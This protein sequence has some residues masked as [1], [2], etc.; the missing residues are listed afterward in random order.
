[1]PCAR[2]CGHR[3]CRSCTIA[4]AGALLAA[5]VSRLVRLQG[6]AAEP[7][8]RSTSASMSPSNSSFFLSASA[9]NSSNTRLSSASSSSNPS[10]CTRSRKAWRPLCLPSTRWLR[11]E[12]DVLGAQDLVGR[13][14]PQHP[15]LVDSGLVRERVLADHRLVARDRHA[16]D[17]RDQ[18]RRRIKPVRLD[19]GRDVEER[20]A[21]LQSHD[22]LLERAVAGALADA[23][24]GALHLPRARH[25]RREAV[26]DGHAEIVVAVDGEADAVDA[27]HVLAQVAEEL[28]ELIRHGVAHGVGD[29]HGGGAGLDGRLD[30]LGQELELGARGVLG[31]EL[32]VL[33]ELARELH[34]V[35]G[36]CAG[37]PPAPC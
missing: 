34:A 36:A 11:G 19:A 35:D 1:M 8:A 5:M 31:R 16:G 24:D 21:R 3:A 33:A 6:P 15:V 22:H 17:A 23:V 30:H 10:A 25:H 29:V 37:S 18:P 32:H 26:G 12:A 14:M 20:R 9:L 7:S 27:A 13:V 4:V 2:R 28:G